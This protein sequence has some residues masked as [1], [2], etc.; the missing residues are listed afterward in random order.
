VKAHFDT[1][2]VPEPGTWLLMALGVA[3]LLT[4]QRQTRTR[5]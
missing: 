5:A 4:H 3:A 1:P 2:P